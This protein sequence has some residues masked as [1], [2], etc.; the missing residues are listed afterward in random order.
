M[1]NDGGE[2]GGIPENRPERPRPNSKRRT[3][4]IIMVAGLLGLF[5]TGTF[6]DLFG[7]TFDFGS[8]GIYLFYGSI[9]LGVFGVFYAILPGNRAGMLTG[10]VALIFVLIYLAGARSRGEI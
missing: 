1:V 9:L 3:A 6:F 8:P 7:Q 2:P 5:A 4:L 10:A